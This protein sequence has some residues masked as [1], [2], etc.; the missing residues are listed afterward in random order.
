MTCP[1]VGLWAPKSYLS[2]V[3]FLAQSWAWSRH[4]II[5]SRIEWRKMIL[6]GFYRVSLGFAGP[7][8]FHGLMG[9]K[10]IQGCA[11]GQR[12]LE[13]AHSDQNCGISRERWEFCLLFIEPQVES[14]IYW[15]LGLCFCFDFIVHSSFHFQFSPSPPFLF[16]GRG[17]S[18][19][20]PR[21]W[22][23]LGLNSSE[24]HTPFSSL[25]VF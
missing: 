6:I 19:C 20:G 15:S 5:V 13:I 12:F 21:S 17:D 11:F 14:G 7:S 18:W 9:R 3:S 1:S 4:L 10:R 2:F 25:S 8:V 16:T 24:W 22:P 23:Q